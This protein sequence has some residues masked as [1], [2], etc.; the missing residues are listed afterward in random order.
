MMNHWLNP[1]ITSTIGRSSSP[2]TGQTAVIS[3]NFITLLIKFFFSWLSLQL[4]RVWHIAFI[5]HYSVIIFIVGHSTNPSHCLNLIQLL[6]QLPLWWATNNSL[7]DISFYSNTNHLYKYNL[8]R[9]FKKITSKFFQTRRWIIHSISSPSRI[10][11][12]FTT[13]KIWPPMWV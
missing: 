4:R 8:L 9:K 3:I 6:P 11:T 1:S 2:P 7:Y 12:P 5:F 10:R 13:I